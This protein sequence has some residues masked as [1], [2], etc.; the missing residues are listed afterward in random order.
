MLVRFKFNLFVLCTLIW[1]HPISLAGQPHAASWVGTLSDTAGKI[2][3]GAQVELRE[4][5]SGRSFTASTDEHGAFSFPELPP[6]TYDVR[7]H[8]DGKL[9]TPAWTRDIE[10]GTHLNL[11]IQMGSVSDGWQIVPALPGDKPSAGSGGQNLSNRQ[12][13]ELPLNKRDFSQL[14]LL[15]AGTMT[16]TNGSAN[17]TQQFAVNGQR[18]ATAVF[19]M[20]G[21]DMTDPAVNGATFTNFNVDAVQE[22][23]SASAVMPAEFG[24][25]A[26]AFTNIK[27]NSGTNLLHGTV[28]EFVRNSAFDARNFFDRQN[29]AQPGRIPQFARNEFG[30]TRSEERRVGKE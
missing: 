26:A 28:F 30:F 22:I 10:P 6:G 21:V 17:F 4:N 19:A 3:P 12:V 14:L 11:P 7:I 23:Q 27:T 25:G 13:S 29:L 18:G 20:D 24:G 8:W 16:D 9:A 5:V 2:I 15:A 1:M